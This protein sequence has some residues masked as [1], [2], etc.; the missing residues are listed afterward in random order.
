MSTNRFLVAQ[1]VFLGFLLA[2]PFSSAL[3]VRVRPRN[4]VPLIHVNNE[5]VRG[6]MFFGIPGRSEIK[7]KKG[8]N[9]VSF[10]FEA[11][12]TEPRHA[13]MH[14][15]FGQKPGTILID[16]IQV[17]EEGSNREVIP[18][19]G[20]DNGM[21]DF[22]RN[23]THWPTGDENTLAKVD[24]VPGPDEG[25]RGV[26]R[27]QLS[28]PSA[29]KW[30]DFHV[31]HLPKLALEKGRNYRAT[32]RIWT[33]V[34]RALNLAFYR[35]GAVF[36]P[37][38]SAPGVFEDQVA[39][40][41]DAGIDFVSLPV[42]MPWPRPGEEPDYSA[43]DA[44]CRNVLR[45]NP[46]ALLLPRVGME[47]PKWW[48]EQYPDHVMVWEDGKQPQ[49]VAVAS[50]QYR[51][52]AAAALAAFV[53]HL[54]EKFGENVAGYHPCGHNTGEWFYR[55]TWERKY[56]GY[57]PATRAAWRHWL[58]RQYPS[59]TELQNAW[60]DDSARFATAEPPA[61]EERHANPGGVFRLPETERRI[62]DFNRFQQ[63]AMADCV[64]ALARSVRQ[65]SE[66]RKLSVFF[67]G[68]VFEFS[69]AYTGPAISGH[70]GLRRVLG[71]PD[72]DIL[73]SPI[74]YCDR[75]LGESAPAMT[76]AESVTLA[77]KLWLYEDDTATYLSSGT[78]P[79]HNE[80]VDTF[81][82]SNNQLIRNVGQEACRNFATWW[83]DLG[84]TGW[85]ND[86]RFWETLKELDALDDPLTSKPQP[87]HPTVAA[88]VDEESMMWVAETGHRV[89]RPLLYEVRGVFARSGAPFGQY[90]FDDVVGGRVD[91]AQVLVFLNAWHLDSPTRQK[92]LQQT[93]GK[94]RVFCYAPA[95]FPAAANS[96]GCDNSRAF[97]FGRCPRASHLWPLPPNSARVSVSKSC[98]SRTRSLPYSPLRMRLPVKSWPPIQMDPPP[99]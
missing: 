33:D 61:P 87:Y 42:P 60:G 74:S 9:Q 84:G 95:S 77:G 4:G 27:V 96:M 5:P 15:R 82:G 31:Y 83:M 38:G 81:E 76:A 73:C 25:N 45:V 97:L 70:Y 18:K 55:R 94:T 11:I 99:L 44:V 89:T 72:I 19:C 28:E 2:A 54:E 46:K 29:R 43:A 79:G 64:V 30:P 65:A 41:R 36:V 6:R 57:A 90:L 67:Y 50:S 8:E 86:R 92:L 22:T 56:S 68:Y 23:W 58:Q 98:P 17:V 62:V 40:A 10:E 93:R 88:V 39:L 71:S 3:E 69:A 78:F 48:K 59:E 35:P 63:E 16:D 7:L 75:G 24:V 80:R 21:S 1:T 47:P 91:T 13:T 12:E 26:L 85:F 66:G 20:F 34:E 14:L 32:L 52:D 37:L 49:G 53:R 51:K